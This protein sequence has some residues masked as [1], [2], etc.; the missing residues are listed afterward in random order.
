MTTARTCSRSGG[1]SSHA[2]WSEPYQPGRFYL[3]ELPPLRAIL[4]GLAEM[5]LLIIDGYADLDPGGPA[6]QPALMVEVI[7]PAGHAGAITCISTMRVRRF[8]EQLIVG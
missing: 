2:S 1:T 5:A 4:D 7:A 6:N 3:R 8:W